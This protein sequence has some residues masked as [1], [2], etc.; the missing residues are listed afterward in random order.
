M[1]NYKF[2][3]FLGCLFVNSSSALFAQ[4]IQMPSMPEM[5][6][7]S[8]PAMPSMPSM[9]SPYYKPQMPGYN[10]KSSTESSTTTNS[11]T[12][13]TTSTSTTTAAKTLSTLATSSLTNS[14]LSASDVSSLYNSGLFD[15]ISSL[16][17]TGTST[18]DFTTT[19]LLQEILQS[20]NDLK[21]Q[22]ANIVQSNQ[23]Q[24]NSANFTD[25]EPSILRFKV[26]GNSL[27]D[28]FKTV[29]FSESEADGTFLLTAD[30]VYYVNQKVQKETVYLLFKTKRNNGSTTIYSVI[31]TL[32]QDTPNE[33]SFLYRMCQQ[34]D[35]EAQK[36]GNLVAV[37]MSREQFS[38]D[39]LLDLD[40]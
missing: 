21:E 7:V 15:N 19:L 16:L 18:S 29:F 8:S 4:Q 6:S 26:N 35:I 27:V 32:M 31:P 30:R 33:N 17:G 1:H 36:T 24:L 38:L 5:P 40:K 12:S 34:I 2:F 22:N 14:S 10:S 23:T 39:I 13:N 37:H 25:R 3:K 11:L 20:L 9:G 28:S